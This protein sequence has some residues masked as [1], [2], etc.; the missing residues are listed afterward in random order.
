MRPFIAPETLEDS[1]HSV[2][3]DFQIELHEKLNTARTLESQK[4][5]TFL[6]KATEILSNTEG[7]TSGK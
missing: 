4:T 6:G 3:T 7:L 1:V 5:I 2:L